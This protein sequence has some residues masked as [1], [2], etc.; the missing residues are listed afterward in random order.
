[1]DSTGSFRDAVALGE[2][3]PVLVPAALIR[4]DEVKRS[5]EVLEVI[6]AYGTLNPR[7]I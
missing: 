3:K 5:V 6:P 7:N 2:Q 1:V 4:R